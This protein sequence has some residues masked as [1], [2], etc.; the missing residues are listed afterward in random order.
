[1]AQNTGK[2]KTK[3]SGSYLW[4]NCENIPQI[5]KA[6][7]KIPKNFLQY[8]FQYIANQG[9]ILHFGPSSRAGVS[10][11]VSIGGKHAMAWLQQ[12]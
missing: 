9:K 12:P 3:I 11:L 6:V 1:L 8:V 7:K 4:L 10:G 2:N 5:S